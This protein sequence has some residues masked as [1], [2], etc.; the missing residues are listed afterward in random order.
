MTQAGARTEFQFGAVPPHNGSEAQRLM[1]EELEQA[2]HLYLL[3]RGVLITP[4][5]NMLLVC[6]ATSEDDLQHLLAA[7][8]GCLAALV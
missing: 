5:H 1:D 4:F 7:F 2:I 8:D 3:N 6:P